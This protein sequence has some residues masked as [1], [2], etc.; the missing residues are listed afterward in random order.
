MNQNIRIAMN[1]MV[2]E[3]RMAGF[4]TGSNTSDLLTQTT[5]W[6][7]GLVPASPYSVVMN[8][9]LVITEGASNPKDDM[10]TFIYGEST[11]S[12]LASEAFAGQTTL[13]LSMSSSE[14][15]E[16]FKV[17][18]II[19]IGFGHTQPSGELEY[20]KIVGISES[21]L[22]IDTDPSTP[23]L[24]DGLDNNY[25][26]GTEVSLMNVTTYALFNDSNDPFYS[27]HTQGHP[28]LKRRCNTGDMEYLVE[29][30]ESLK[31]EEI[32]DDLR[33]TL[34]ARTSKMEPDYINPEFGDHFRRRTLISMVRVRN[35]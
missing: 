12:T 21:V 29:D 7:S 9:D 34:I 26:S 10:I 33:I 22:S 30:I 20:A 35:K 28:A 4:K 8:D 14:V 3:I 18:D 5:V 23:S 27:D 13:T 32:G 25:R 11:S 16:N 15:A 1:R 17:G 2:N 24:Q 6:T 31:I 19:Y